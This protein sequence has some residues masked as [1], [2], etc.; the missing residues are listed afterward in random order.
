VPKLR[1]YEGK[2]NP[3]GVEILVQMMLLLNIKEKITS[4]TYLI[5]N[6]RCQTI[7]PLNGEIIHLVMVNFRKQQSGQEMVL[8]WQN[9]I[10]N[11]WY[12]TV[13]ELRIR[14]DGSDFPELPEVY[15][16]KSYKVHFEFGKVKV[17][18]PLG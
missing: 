7:N 2:S 3:A 15:D 4:I 5:L 14:P 16:K 9:Q 11:D 8:G 1:K 12:E 13:S 6:L 17:F 10:K 18:H